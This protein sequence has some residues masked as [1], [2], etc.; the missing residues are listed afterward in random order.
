MEDVTVNEHE[1]QNFVARTIH[2]SSF[3]RHVWQILFACS[4][5]MIWGAIFCVFLEGKS[6]YD[7]AFTLWNDQYAKISYDDKGYIILPQF[8]EYT[9]FLIITAILVAM[10]VNSRF[11]RQIT[12]GIILGTGI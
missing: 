8:V 11:F 7:L 1:V 2:S 12:A 5:F 3:S 9:V 4:L 10:L 6:S